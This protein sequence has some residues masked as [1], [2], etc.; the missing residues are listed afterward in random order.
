MDDLQKLKQ[1]I[2]GQRLGSNLLEKRFETESY[3]K[4][5]RRLE[6]DTTLTIVTFMKFVNRFYFKFY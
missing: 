4:M 3:T 6:L 1:I 2:K 5:R